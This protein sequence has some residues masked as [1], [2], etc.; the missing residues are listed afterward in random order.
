MTTMMRGRPGKPD[1]NVKPGVGPQCPKET[2]PRE[3]GNRGELNPGRDCTDSKQMD[4]YSIIR[5]RRSR[6][7]GTRVYI[8]SLSR[9]FQADTAHFAARLEHGVLDPSTSESDGYSTHGHP[10]SVDSR[11][12][13]DLSHTSSDSDT[14]KGKRKRAQEKTREQEAPR[15]VT[16]KQKVGNPAE[17]TASRL[18]LSNS[19]CMRGFLI[20]AIRADV[21][22]RF[23]Q[24]LLFI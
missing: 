4:L 11:R 3:G 5:N 10:G 20:A 6:S 2:P 9:C 17:T 15:P 14:R 18:T 7:T 13:D 12:L 1:P 24:Y 16:K 8:T 21:T 19:E 23:S 22:L